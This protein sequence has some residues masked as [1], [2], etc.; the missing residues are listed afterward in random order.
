MSAADLVVNEDHT[1]LRA[2]CAADAAP[3]AELGMG[4]TVSLRFSLAGSNSRCYSVSAVVDGRTMRGFVAKEAVTGADEFEDARRE[5]STAGSFVEVVWGQQ[6]GAGNQPVNRTARPPRAR[7]G[8]LAADFA[9][10]DL[11]GRAYRLGSLRG[12]VV[13]LDFWASWCGPCRR[14]MPQIEA[15]HRDYGRR[16]LVVLGVNSEPA[17][18]ASSYL[19]EN[20]YSFPTLVDNGGLVGRQYGVSGIPTT[21]VI[22]SAGRVSSYLVGLHSEK[23]IRA[24]VVKAGL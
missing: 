23:D 17:D 2:Q 4:T 13:L 9:L 5:A 19:R 3:V 21:V 10:P 1:V 12:R 22:D 14:S 7:G 15:V 16:G 18:V 20:G 8:D 11:S 6:P 24:A